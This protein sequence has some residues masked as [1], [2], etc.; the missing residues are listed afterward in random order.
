MQILD[1]PTRVNPAAAI[2]VLSPSWVRHFN[3][4]YLSQEMQKFELCETLISSYDEPLT[5]VK[6]NL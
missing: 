3:V 4:P 5:M 2:V 1:P 6:G